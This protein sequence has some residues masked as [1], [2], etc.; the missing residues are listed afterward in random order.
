M[1][2]QL[3]S[4]TLAFHQLWC[5]IS[6]TGS[7]VNSVQDVYGGDKIFYYGGGGQGNHLPGAYSRAT[8]S[9][10]GSIYKSTAIAQEK[11]GEIWVNSLMMGEGVRADFEHSEVSIFLGKNPWQSHGIPRAR[12]L[13]KEIAKDPNRKM[14]V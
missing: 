4:C 11:T 14:I 12:V 1:Q 9:A 7:G 2:K 13:L 10:F 8:L 6:S 3:V 5:N